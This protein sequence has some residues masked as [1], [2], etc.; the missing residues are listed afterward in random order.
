MAGQPLIGELAVLAVLTRDLSH[1]RFLVYVALLYTLSMTAGSLLPPDNT[2]GPLIKLALLPLAQ[3]FLLLGS[4]V[5]WPHS[6]S[7]ILLA[8]SA[9]YAGIVLATF[10]F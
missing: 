5:R 3:C 6:H 1:G 7:L 8:S 4:R 10:G 9:F 2:L